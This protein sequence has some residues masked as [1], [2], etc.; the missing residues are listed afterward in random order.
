MNPSSRG[1][2]WRKVLNSSSREMRRRKILNLRR[3]KLWRRRKNRTPHK[4]RGG[5]RD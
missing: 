1:R 2:R 5:E 4:G 3:K